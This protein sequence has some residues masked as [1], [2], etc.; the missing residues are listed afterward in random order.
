MQ[1][2]R[3][4]FAKLGLLGLLGAGALAAIVAR[5]EG[6]AAAVSSPAPDAPE[7]TS[8]DSPEPSLAENPVAASE[9]PSLPPSERLSCDA[10]VQRVT[11][12]LGLADDDVTEDT[13]NSLAMLATGATYSQY[14]GDAACSE[15]L[16]RAVAAD[17]SCGRALGPVA[18]G[19]LAG[20]AFPADLASALVDGARTDCLKRILPPLQ[21]VTN[22]NMKLAKSVEKIARGGNEELR[23]GAW[24]VLGSL[25]QAAHAQGN[26]EVVRYVEGAIRE[27]LASAKAS[28][29]TPALEAA[30]NAGCESCAGELEAADEDADW[31]VR[32]AATAARRFIPQRRG[33]ERMCKSLER[34]SATGVREHAAWS[35][36]WRA[37]HD[38]LRVGCLAEAAMKDGTP[39]VRRAATRSLT[40]LVGRSKRALGA[41]DRL[42]RESDSEEVRK[43]ATEFLAASSEGLPAEGRDVGL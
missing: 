39:D 12:G 21:R 3:S 23:E 11:R 35:M 33:V 40:L 5:S 20:D 14:G 16:Y 28:D 17:P 18:S 8:V 27:K 38:E 22:V 30:G 6:R 29:R 37:D 42:A 9:R 13:A 10:I 43:I 19:M 34:D 26:E 31:R 2:H 15:R 24:L 32:R 7:V 25:A 1:A 4:A 36:L 41:V